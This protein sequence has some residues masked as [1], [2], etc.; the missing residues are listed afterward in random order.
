MCMCICIYLLINPDYTTITIGDP[1]SNG[2]IFQ[3][4][5]VYEEL[6][7]ELG[8]CSHDAEEHFY[9]GDLDIKSI[10]TGVFANL[11]SLR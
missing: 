3:L 5:D 6:S 8:T 7:R 10:A 1:D 9:F 2:C 11:S 4:H